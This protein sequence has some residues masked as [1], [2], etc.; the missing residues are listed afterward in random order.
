MLISR[1]PRM[2][3]H[4]VRIQIV[5]TETTIAVNYIDSPMSITITHDGEL[6]RHFLSSI[7]CNFHTS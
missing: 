5:N 7:I 3:L 4:I 6:G 1:I 2:L